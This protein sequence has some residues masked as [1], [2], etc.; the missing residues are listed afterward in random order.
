MYAI[1]EEGGGQRKVQKDDVILIDLIEGGEA[2]PGK[3]VKFD[4]VLCVG[5]GESVAKIGTPIVSGA[6]VTAE[7]IESVVQGEKLHIHKFRRRKGYRRKTGH[8]QAYTKVKVTA[9]N[10]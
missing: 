8:R 10:G 3:T 6:S 5:D 4:R 9:I 1:I 7:V 2:A